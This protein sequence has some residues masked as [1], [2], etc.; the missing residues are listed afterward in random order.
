MKKC[1][2]CAEEIQDEALTCRYCKTDLTNPRQK[3]AKTSKIIT[4]IGWIVVLCLACIGFS[5]VWDLFISPILSTSSTSNQPYP[6]RTPYLTNT[7]RPSILSSNST[8]TYQSPYLPVS[9]GCA[10]AEQITAS[11]A[12]QTLC[13]FGYAH[14]VYSTK[15]T[16]TRITFSPQP[17][18]FF[19]YSTRYVYDDGHGNPLSSGDCVGI[20][21]TIQLIS[22]IPS[23]DIDQAELKNCN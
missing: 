17:N 20:T 1:P 18:T 19:I 21:G 2:Y 10:P 5:V 23:I 15:E 16:P 4:I 14:Q 12:G 3:K 13:I 11:M 8:P 9:N 7:P 6:T 22:N